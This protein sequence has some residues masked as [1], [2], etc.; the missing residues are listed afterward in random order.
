MFGHVVKRFQKKANIN[1]KIYDVQTRSKGN[2]TMK[3]DQLIECN[4]RNIF[5]EKWYTKCGGDTNPR[6]F[7][8]NQN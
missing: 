1:F 8:K 7:L 2:R 5:L 4:M 6:P 3:F